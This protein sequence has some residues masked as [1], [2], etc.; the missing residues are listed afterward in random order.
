MA[1]IDNALYRRILGDEIRRTRRRPGWTRE[2]LRARMG[3]TLSLQTLATY[4]LGTRHCSLIRFVEI[5]MAL[6]EPPSDVLARTHRR[7]TP[8]PADGLLVHLNAIV[9]D[10]PPTLEPLRRWAQNRLACSGI[11][12]GEEE[13]LSGAALEHLARLCGMS[14]TEVIATVN[15]FAPVPSAS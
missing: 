9:R 6:G 1:N 4:E 12:S 2:E 14:V 5:C 7:V 13:I 3:G 11:P 15:D 8:D 10:A